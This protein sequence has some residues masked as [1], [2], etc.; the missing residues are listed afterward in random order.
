MMLC[1]MAEK[2][3]VHGKIREG[4]LKLIALERKGDMVDRGRLRGL[5]RM[6][7]ELGLYAPLEQVICSTVIRKPSTQGLRLAVSGVA[8]CHPSW[9]C[10]QQCLIGGASIHD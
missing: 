1:A 7:V 5:V 9:L 6:L 3:Q 4:I 8:P 10:A 2:S